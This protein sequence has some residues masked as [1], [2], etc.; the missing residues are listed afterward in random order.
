MRRGAR[1]LRAEP[2]QRERLD[3]RERLDVREQQAPWR[4]GRPDERE[5][6][7]PSPAARLDVARREPRGVRPLEYRDVRPPAEPRGARAHRLAD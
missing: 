6:R 4:Q 2:W 3:E 5:A 7:E 1:A